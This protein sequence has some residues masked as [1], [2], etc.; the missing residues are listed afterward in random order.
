MKNKIVV[1]VTGAK[2]DDGTGASGARLTSPL[3]GRPL[4]GYLLEAVSSLDPAAAYCIIRQKE[5]DAAK[6]LS[7]WALSRRKMIRPCFLTDRSPAAGGGTVPDL[8]SALRQAASF[9]EKAPRKDVLVLS[10]GQVLLQA[11]TL[12][13][14][15]SA[16]RRSGCSLALLGAGGNVGPGGV[17]AFRAADVLAVLPRLSRVTREERFE[18]LVRILGEQGK[19]VGLF[20]CPCPEELLPV[21]VGSGFDEAASVLRR[22]KNESLARKGVSLLDP[23]STWIDPDAEIGRGTII[24]PSVVI[25]GPSRIGRDCR[26]YPHVQIM[27]SRVG[28]GVKILGFT[29]IEEAVLEDGVQAGPYSRLR[30]GSVLRRDSKVGNFVE[31][32]NTDFGPKSKAMHLSY[33]GDSTVEGKVNVGAGTITCNYDGVRKSRTHI[34]TGAF[35]GS[36]TELVAP[37]K[38]GKGAYVA[39]G[40]TITKDVGSKSLAVA[41]AR[42]EEKP[43]WVLKKPRG[44]KTRRSRKA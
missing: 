5:R 32:K 34:G 17:M 19:K 42:Q 1:L 43:G 16:H 23:H 27:R 20:E 3:L 41:R 6:S 21:S 31:M 9:L 44:R 11:R 38:V 36:G 26:I 2:E 28:N 10:S 14:F 37:V 15:L 39:A 8:F 30:P 35:I 29:S 4:A 18:V 22:R 7:E 12:K 33:I 24:S 13:A 40:S 25:E